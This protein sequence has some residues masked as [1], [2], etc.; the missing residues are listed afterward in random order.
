MADVKIEAVAEVDDAVQGI[1]SL[2]QAAEDIS[3]AMKK[4]NEE[5][6]KPQKALDK[7]RDETKSVSGAKRQLTKDIK[8]ATRAKKEAEQATQ[9]LHKTLNILGRVVMAVVGGFA[10]AYTALVKF[11]EEAVKIGRADAARNIDKMTVAV[12][13]LKQVLLSVPLFT[14]RSLADWFNEA[15]IGATNL[16]NT[17]SAL[18][19]QKRVQEID[20]QLKRISETGQVK[21]GQGFF[22]PVF[23]D[24]V[25]GETEALQKERG[26][27]I[28]MVEALVKG[29]DV[30]ED[31]VIAGKKLQQGNTRTG[32]SLTDLINKQK[33]LNDELR[34]Q[35]ALEDDTIRAGDARAL[36]AL[37]RGGGGGSFG[38]GLR[39]QSGGLANGGGGAGQRGALGNMG[40][41]GPINVT[42]YLGDRPVKN[43]VKKTIVDDWYKKSNPK[44]GGKKK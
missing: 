41:G 33:K 17:L 13:N 3:P 1:N 20:A 43:I 29:K 40:Q 16:A 34:D 37:Q 11:R 10:L 39:P 26:E 22:G 19:I 35:M 36:A 32:E 2:E 42:V 12:D 7:L 21:Q 8:D 4:W 28:K 44:P 18:S 30:I 14:S 9:R 23:V 31:V 27:L 6:A 5:V 25:E 15:A 38:A 24:A